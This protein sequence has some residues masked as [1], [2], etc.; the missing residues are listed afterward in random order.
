MR[1]SSAKIQSVE[2]GEDEEWN[3]IPTT[4]ESANTSMTGVQKTNLS[5]T[6]SSL[7]QVA[8]QGML[9]QSRPPPPKKEPQSPQHGTEDDNELN[10]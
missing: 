3:Y 5:G 9:M 8:H 10:E 7:A 6:R 4:L 1:H 2:V